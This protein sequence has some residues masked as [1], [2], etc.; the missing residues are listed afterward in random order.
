MGAPVMA[1]HLRKEKTPSSKAPHGSDCTCGG[2]GTVYHAVPNG[3]MY[4]FSRYLGLKGVPISLLCG[5]C[6]C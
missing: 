3:S 5:L 1:R 4:W 2:L 6:M